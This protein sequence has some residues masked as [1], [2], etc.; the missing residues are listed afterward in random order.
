VHRFLSEITNVHIHEHCG[1]PLAQAITELCLRHSE[2]SNQTCASTGKHT[3]RCSGRDAGRFPAATLVTPERKD[4]SRLGHCQCPG[5]QS[6][7]CTL[8]LPGF[9]ASAHSVRPSGLEQALHVLSRGSG[10]GEVAWARVLQPTNLNGPGTWK[11][12]LQ[13]WASVWLS[14]SF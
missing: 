5:I 10:R 14:P 9:L 6:N 8:A 2:K 1:L 3:P 7:L 12:S 13:N 11:H 4:R